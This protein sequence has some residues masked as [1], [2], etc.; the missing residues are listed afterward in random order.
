MRYRDAI[1][2]LLAPGWLQ[3]PKNA[4]W[5]RASGDLKD[6]LVERCKA[7]VK[8][9]FPLVA[10][11]DALDVAGAERQ[12]E[13]G[14]AESNASFAERVAGAWN[15]WRW[16][17]TARGLL[18]A[19][20][21]SGYTTT[22][23][24]IVNGKAFTL[25]AGELVTTPLPAGTWACD[26]TPLFWNKFVLVLPANP[27]GEDPAADDPRVELLRRLVRRWKSAHSTCA[28][29]VVINSGR[30]WDWPIVM[31]DGTTPRTWA[32]QDTAGW[33]WQGNVALH[34]TP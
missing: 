10:P 17:G 28:D 33:L 19:L 16:G 4:A 11:R 6:S 25:V 13:R 31:G 22:V 1:P 24:A 27:W 18:Q 15:I 20:S 2:R 29:I 5:L 32:A 14:P 26:A 7:A 30:L 34:F 9:R 8:A 23:L 3:T 12:L 21:D